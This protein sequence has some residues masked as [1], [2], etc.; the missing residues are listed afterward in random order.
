MTE[1]GSRQAV[2]DA[3]MFG[4]RFSPDR[5]MSPPPKPKRPRG[6]PAGMPLRHWRYGV[7]PQAEGMQI[8]SIGRVELRLGEALRIEMTEPGD[9]GAETAHVQYYIVTDAGPWAL[10]LSCDRSDLED[11]ETALRDLRPPFERED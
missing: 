4:R 2:H 5:W 6:D 3:V 10:W 8:R 11:R 1:T 9:T 7:H